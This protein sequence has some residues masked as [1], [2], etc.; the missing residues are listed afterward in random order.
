[1]AV[2][3]DILTKNV[4][5]MPLSSTLFAKIAPWTTSDQVECTNGEN[6][7]YNLDDLQNQINDETTRINNMPK[8]VFSNVEPETIA[9][10]TI[11]MVYETNGE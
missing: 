7:Q 1:M 9:K 10:N 5:R 8:I 11:V 6:V 2:Y 3:K 4:M